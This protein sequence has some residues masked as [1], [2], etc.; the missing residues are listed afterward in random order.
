VHETPLF[1]KLKIG[2]LIHKKVR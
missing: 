2:S 1:L